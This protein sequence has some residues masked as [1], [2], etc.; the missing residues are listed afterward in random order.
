MISFM[1]CHKEPNVLPIGRRRGRVGELAG[2]IPLTSACI[3]AHR[4]EFYTEKMLPG[5]KSA[6]TFP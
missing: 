2:A 4:C 6:R 3:E 5:G 1:H